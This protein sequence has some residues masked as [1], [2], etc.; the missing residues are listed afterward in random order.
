MERE[1]SILDFTL[2][3]WLQENCE[4]KCIYNL[5]PRATTL[6]SYKNIFK[7]TIDQEKI[8]KYIQVTQSPDTS[9]LH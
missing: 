8:I 7:N 3:K 1:V 5:I 4:K 2:I 9:K 6:K